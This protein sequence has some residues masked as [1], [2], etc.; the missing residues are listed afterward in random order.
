[1][2]ALA[3]NLDNLIPALRELLV[4]GPN[5]YLTEMIPAT[6]LI[7]ID[8]NGAWR[9]HTDDAATLHVTGT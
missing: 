1:V 9:L 5:S 7:L 2:H 3:Q 4:H 8:A 6:D